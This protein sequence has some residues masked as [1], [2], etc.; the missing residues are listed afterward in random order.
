MFAELV[1]NGRYQVLGKLGEGGQGTTYDGIDRKEGRPV[2]IKRFEVRGAKSWKDVEL[3]EREA[4]VLAALSHPALPAHIDHFEEDGVLYLVMQKIEGENL[5]ALAKRGALGRDDVLRF[6][7][8]AA[9]ILGYLHGRSPPV[10]HRDINPKNVIRRLDGSFAIVDFGAV[11]DRL[12]PDGGSTVVGTFGYMAPEQFQGRA[13]PASDVYAV[14]ATALRLLTGTDPEELPHRGLGIDVRAALGPGA[15]RGLAEMLSRMLEPDPDRRASDLATLLDGYARRVR[16]T[17]WSDYVPP[18]APFDASR[19]ARRKQR[20]AEREMYRSWTRRKRRQRRARPMHGPPLLFAVLGIHVAMLAVGLLFNAFLPILLMFLSIFFG[21]ALRQAARRLERVG[22][23]ARV[24]L[25]NSR[26]F[27]LHG[28]PAGESP[29]RVHEDEGSTPEQLIRV[30]G[31][32]I[33][34]EG[35]PASARSADRRS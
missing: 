11:R 16:G 15:D 26:D 10:I 32:V 24:A 14:G 29:L 28:T 4:N 8:D 23:E 17:H 19:E 18:A 1:K 9:G 30:S 20:R 25:G 13:L 6:L 2:A 35:T 22:H 27:L 21:P 7:S 12:R 3:A 5:A 33:D 31:D 34:A